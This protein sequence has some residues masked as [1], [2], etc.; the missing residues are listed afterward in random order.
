VTYGTHYFLGCDGPGGRRL[1]D[2]RFYLEGM[3]VVNQI[4]GARLLVLR[5][6][7]ELEL[8]GMR[9]SRPPSAYM[10]IKKELGLSG[11]RERVLAQMDEIRNE[12]LG[13]KDEADA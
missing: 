13:L 10:I 2:G 3:M 6:M 9:R 4:Q 7:L 5:S 8:K 1:D 12:L 11:S